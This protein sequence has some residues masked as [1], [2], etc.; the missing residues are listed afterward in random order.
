MS[1][2]WKHLGSS[3]HITAHL[4]LN[5]IESE[6][7]KTRI[8]SLVKDLDA[9]LKRK[10]ASKTKE[11]HYHT[12]SDLGALTTNL[13]A[14]DIDAEYITA[15]ELGMQGCCK[16]RHNQK[17]LYTAPHDTTTGNTTAAPVN[18]ALD[19]PQRDPT[20]QLQQPPHTPAPENQS[21]TRTTQATPVPQEI[22]DLQDWYR[23]SQAS[24]ANFNTHEKPKS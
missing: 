20:G 18:H 8:I 1:G 22:S 7:K 4:S 6:E 17:R 19:D 2:P 12:A 23:L 10:L 5:P 14:G 13:S 3:E 11:L 16:R 15:L 24:A 9:I 21:T